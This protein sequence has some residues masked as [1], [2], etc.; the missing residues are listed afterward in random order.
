MDEVDEV[1]NFYAKTSYHIDNHA[2][3]KPVAYCEAFEFGWP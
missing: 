1:D 3:A 2:F